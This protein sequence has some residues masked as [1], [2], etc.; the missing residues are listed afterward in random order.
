[1]VRYKRL[2]PIIF[3][4]ISS[5][6]PEGTNN[7]SNPLPTLEPRP[8]YILEIAPSESE[9]IPIQMFE[10]KSNEPGVAADIWDDIDAYGS[11]ICL[12]VET[13]ILAQEGDNFIQD[14]TVRDRVTIAIDDQEIKDV[15]VNSIL[16]QGIHVV[17]ADGQYIKM[18]VEPKLICGYADIGVGAH[19][20]LFQF[21]QTSGDILEYRWSFTLEE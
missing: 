5:C 6:L 9:V 1:M 2:F 14:S 16:L 8:K 12:K 20:V 18:G 3:L 13:S 11:Q 15:F 19:E 21:R 4:L 10:A 17:D 7:T